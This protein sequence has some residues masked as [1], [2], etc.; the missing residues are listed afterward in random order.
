M[1]RLAGGS[2]ADGGASALTTVRATVNDPNS[3]VHAA[4]IRALGDWKTVDA[5]PAL[6]DLAKASSNPND[7]GQCVRSA[8][9][10]A[11]DSD[12]PAAQRLS[13]CQQAA[14]LIQQD[15]EKKQL[16]G[17]L[18]SIKTTESLALVVP[19]LE[20]AATKEEASAATVA[21]AEALLKGGSAAEAAPKLIEP[22]QKVAQATSNADLTR[23]ARTALRQAQNRASGR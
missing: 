20:Q 1:R 12:A 13:I 11:A 23:R 10:L 16:L 21:I 15:D 5:A 19:F 6:L 7:R 18:G 4:A 14:G 3:E 22:L 2:D 8:L 17:A 9:R